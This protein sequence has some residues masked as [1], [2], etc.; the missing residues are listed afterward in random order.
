MFYA[1]VPNLKQITRHHH[2]QIH[3][4]LLS[5]STLRMDVCDPIDNEGG[6][7]GTIKTKSRIAAAEIPTR[8]LY[9]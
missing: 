5:F 9:G 3:M 6:H 1:I 4:L 7:G 2:S 8:Q